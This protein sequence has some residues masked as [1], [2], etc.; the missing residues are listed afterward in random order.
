MKR[1]AYASRGWKTLQADYIKRDLHALHVQ[2]LHSRLSKDISGVSLE[3]AAIHYDF[4]SHSAICIPAARYIQTGVLEHAESYF[5]L[6]TLAKQTSFGLLAHNPRWESE[7]TSKLQM[8]DSITAAVLCGLTPA[9]L[10][11]L[12]FDRMALEREKNTHVERAARHPNRPK[13]GGAEKEAARA[14]NRLVRKSSAAR[15]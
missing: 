8:P 10:N 4:L 9:A 3:E 2:K 11:L 13:A 1:T 6:S 14:G 12:A 5:C 7:R 15:G